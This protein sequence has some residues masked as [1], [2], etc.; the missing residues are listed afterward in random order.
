MR[1]H[2]V[3]RIVVLAVVGFAAV[4]AVP[5]RQSATG[6]TE[7]TPWPL[8][9]TTDAG[10]PSVWNFGQVVAVATGADGNIV[11]V[12]DAPGHVM[13]ARCARWTAR[14]WPS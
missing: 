1:K 11:W 8:P 9:A 4:T 2:A 3:R 7:V 6:Y 13:A 14:S 5:A 10:T 12:V